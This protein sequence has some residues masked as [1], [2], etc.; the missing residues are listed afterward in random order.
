MYGLGKSIKQY[1][2]SITTPGLGTIQPALKRL[3]KQEYIKSDKFFTE[4]GKPYYY[5]S[6]TNDGK[7]ALI[8]EIL[9]KPSSNP[10]HLFPAAKLKLICSNILDDNEKKELCTT[11]KSEIT[12]VYNL[13]D[14]TITS[15]FFANNYSAKIVMNNLIC[16]CKNTLDMI[17]G[18]K[19]AGN[20]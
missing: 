14:K 5:Y 16:E 15:D 2:G 6:I 20:S 7:N 17:E 10:I 12:K 1:F 9:A 19:N 4:G 3:E 8:T 11:L 18:L 13:A